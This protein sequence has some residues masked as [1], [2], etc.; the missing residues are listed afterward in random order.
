MSRD[1]PFLHC[2]VTTSVTMLKIFSNVSGGM[3]TGLPDKVN[4]SWI[5]TDDSLKY[6][7]EMYSKTGFRLGK[8]WAYNKGFFR[9]S[10]TILTPTCKYMYL[11]AAVYEAQG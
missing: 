2:T 6:F 5:L 4:R 8:F 3:F 11:T 7:V 10:A 9:Q 1:F